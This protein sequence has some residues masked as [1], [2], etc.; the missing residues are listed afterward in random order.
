M[1]AHPSDDDLIAYGSGGAP[2]ARAASIRAHM[3]GC[4]SC[5]T[6]VAAIQSIR[7]DFDGAWGRFMTEVS[8]EATAEK[9]EAAL[10]RGILSLTLSEVSERLGLSEEK[11]TRLCN[12]GDIPAARV[13]NEWRFNLDRVNRWMKDRFEEQRNE[14]PE[15]KDELND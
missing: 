10:D 2:K 13:G 8:M 1:N 7:S 9:E 5:R 14:I 15:R 11:L 6:R 12:E 3:A 4:E